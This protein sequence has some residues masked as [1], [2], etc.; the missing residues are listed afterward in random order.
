MNVFL[1][2]IGLW[3][4]CAA[5]PLSA[6]EPMS[7]KACMEYALQHST[8]ME[9]QRA[10]YDDAILQRRDAL[11][12]A[13]TPTVAAGTSVTTNFG[14]AVDPETNAYISTTSFSNNYSVNASI[15]L[16]DG[17]SNV[18]R[19]RMAKTAVSMGLSETQKLKDEICLAV[20][21]RYF[22]VTF[23]QEM[24]KAW[25]AQ[26]ATARQ[27]LE[28]M[29][30]QYELGRKGYA[31]VVQ[32]EADLAE[33]E[34]QFIQCQNQQREALLNLKA[35][36]L[37]SSADSLVL[38]PLTSEGAHPLPCHTEEERNELIGFA[39]TYQPKVMVARGEVDKARYNLRA[40]RGG[41]FPTL[42]LHGGWSTNY[43]TYPGKSDYQAP[44]FSRQF[45]NNGGEFIQLSL[46]FPLYNRLA[47]HSQLKRRKHDFER[48]QASYR[49]TLK[50]V[51]TEVARA[52]QDYDGARAAAL[53]A[54]K[55]LKAQ[56]ESYR[57]TEKK[58]TQGLISPIEFQT[59]SNAFLQAQA[60]R[61]N[62][63]LQVLL[64]ESLV[65]FYRGTSYLEQQN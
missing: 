52:L 44:S 30:K 19:F 54:D 22:E 23:E 13:F 16:F 27:H 63:Q 58:F 48:A 53:Q 34:Y 3:M 39:Q 2:H 4:G 43:Y 8:Q 37:W 14:R 21:E 10:D 12:Q 61:M 1:K 32:T 35:L 40:A 7:L 29:Q 45:H 51:E 28:L 15:T 25:A 17:L 20:M 31:D 5:L 46:T 49:Q 6:Q 56:H 33:R 42:S 50:E 41:F 59:V 64:K 24:C 57:L 9:I 65:R 11:L 26:V 38:A 60:Q 47:Q 18:N 36:M 62:A 55:R